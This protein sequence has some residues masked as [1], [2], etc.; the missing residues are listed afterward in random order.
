[1]A[2][3]KETR[4]EKSCFPSS[5]T[6]TLPDGTTSR[7]DSL[8]AGDT[9]VAATSDGTLITDKVSSLSIA[10]PDAEAV[11]VTLS[12]DSGHELTLTP[13]HHL[14]VGASCC[15]NLKKAKAV[16]VGE[17]VWTAGAVTTVTKKGLVIDQGLHSPVL[18]NGG[19]PVIDG[20]VT[21][22]DRIEVVSVASLLLPFF[23]LLLTATG[24]GP[25]WKRIVIADDRRPTVDAATPPAMLSS[26]DSVF[27]LSI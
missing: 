17:L 1:L 2:P 21:S 6:V 3:A 26:S 9:I 14:P 10:E 19:F 22:F 20:V 18:I 11:F 13:E 16:D 15:S 24:G 5:A 27:P 23:E 12:T 4:C 8:R 7:V 25:M